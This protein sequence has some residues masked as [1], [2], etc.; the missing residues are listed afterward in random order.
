MRFNHLVFALLSV[1]TL[2]ACLPQVQAGL[3]L[4]EAA[5][6]P[7]AGIVIVTTTPQVEPTAVI[8]EPEASQPPTQEPAAVTAPSRFVDLPTQVTLNVNLVY[9]ERWMEVQQT[10]VVDNLSEDSWTEVVFNVPGNFIEGAFFLESAS[11]SSGAEATAI[12]PSFA[13]PQT[14]LKIELPQP[15]EPGQTLQIDLGYVVLVPPVAAG[16]WPPNGLTGWRWDAAYD[17]I[18]AGEWYPAIVPYERGS[19]WREWDYRLVGDPTFYPLVDYQLNVSSDAAVTVASGGLVERTVDEASGQATTRFAIEDGRGIAFVASDDYQMV[20]TVYEG[21]PVRSYYLAPYA[22]GGKAALDVARDSL[23]L[24]TELF[25]PYPFD[26]LTIAVNGFLG[27]MEYSAFASISDFVYF[28]YGGRINSVFHALIAHEIAHMWFYGAVGNDQANEPW[29]D[30]SIAFYS[31]LLYYERY[32]PGF[33]DW[34]W[35]TRVD[36]YEPTGPVDANIYDY[37]EAQTFIVN[38]YGQAAYFMRDLRAVMGDDAFFAFLRDYY[39]THQG[40]IVT[41]EDFFRLAQAHAQIDLGPLIDQYFE[42][43]PL[44]D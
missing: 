39:E 22:E 4:D 38:M 34:W 29:L 19:G 14:M 2:A 5:P 18:Q 25:G 41:S 37:E 31:E 10:V 11:V 16:D 35:F 33:I 7:T 6:T 36:F 28:T 40:G 3:P 1:F 42:E 26:D 12:T 9:Y 43:P 13:W 15:L 27:G 32:Y 24:F 20:E 23:A 21:I 44:L 8:A 30:E 17:L